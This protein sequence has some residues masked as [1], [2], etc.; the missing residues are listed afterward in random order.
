MNTCRIY[1][2]FMLQGLLLAGAG[3]AS[4]PAPAGESAVP[5]VKLQALANGCDACHGPGGVSS[6]SDIPSLAGQGADTLMSAIAKF[7]TYERHCPATRPG[8]GDPSALA[9][10]MCE[11]SGQLTEAE[12]R[13]L[14]EH[15]AAGQPVPAPVP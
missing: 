1:G 7:R 5:E 3:P 4:T 13:A 2:A 6:R 9:R 11:I 14:A 15:Y 10:N 12:A 8:H